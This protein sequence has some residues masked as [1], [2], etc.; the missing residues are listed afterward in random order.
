MAK[1]ILFN[2][3]NLLTSFIFSSPCL[4]VLYHGGFIWF[5][6]YKFFNFEV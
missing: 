2:P 1:T 5:I 3:S 6:Y 4:S